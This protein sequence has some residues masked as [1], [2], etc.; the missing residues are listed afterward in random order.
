MCLKL[1][2]TWLYPQIVIPLGKGE[3][4]DQQLLSKMDIGGTREHRELRKKWTGTACRFPLGEH[5]S[6][7]NRRDAR[8]FLLSLAAGYVHLMQDSPPSPRETHQASWMDRFDGEDIAKYP[9]V[10]IV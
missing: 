1:G 8:I 10:Q 6:Y 9:L 2:Y 7:A 4:D 3:N 5:D